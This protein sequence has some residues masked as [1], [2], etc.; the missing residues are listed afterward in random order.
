MFAVLYL[1]LNLPK[2]GL[3]HLT[4]QP[5]CKKS[6]SAKVT[7]GI[8]N[9]FLRNYRY[10]GWQHNYTTKRTQTS[11]ANEQSIYSQLFMCSTAVEHIPNYLKTEG[12]SPSTILAGERK[13]RK[14]EIE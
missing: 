5:Y 3:L 7:D 13:W 8:I 6:R 9:L 1:D 14:K 10:S 4:G 12:L 2:S 11:Q